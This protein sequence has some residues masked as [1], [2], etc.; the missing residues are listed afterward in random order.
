VPAPCTYDYAVVRVV[1]HVDRGEFVNAGIIVSC[2][3][4]QYL[5]ARIEL[6]EA[7]VLALAP[8]LD[9]TS[10]RR[11]LAALPAICAG[12]PGAGAFAELSARQRFDWLVAPRSA[13]IQTSPVHSGRCTD[14]DGMLERLMTRMV[15][16]PAPR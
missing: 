2:T 13:S 8:A 16:S 7:R 12:G 1:P 15:R 6:D 14:L 5:Q 9:L 11:A 10:I 3:S 4:R